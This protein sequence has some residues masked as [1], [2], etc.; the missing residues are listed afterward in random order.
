MPKPPAST[1]EARP[2]EIQ[3]DAERLRALDRDALARRGAADA[4]ADEAE[5]LRQHVAD[6][7]QQIARAG[8]TVSGPNTIK[9][10]GGNPLVWI[11]RNREKPPFIDWLEARLEEARRDHDAA[12]E[13]SGELGRAAGQAGAVARSAREYAEKA[14]LV[15][16]AGQSAFGAFG[17]T[18]AQASAHMR[19]SSK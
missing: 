9:A 14:G 18:D 8:G 6:L 19:E 16:A 5:R 13:L 1:A 2:P 17:P 7:T 4:A 10:G 15:P 11:K 12:R 3:L